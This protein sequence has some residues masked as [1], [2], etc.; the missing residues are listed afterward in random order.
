VPAELPVLSQRRSEFET[1]G[2]RL[3]VSS[4]VVIR[5][6]SDKFLTAQFLQSNGFDAPATH[7]S[8]DSATDAIAEDRLFFPLMVK[9][10]WGSASIGLHKVDSLE[11]LEMAFNSTHRIVSTGALANLGGENSNRVSEQVPVDNV[12]IQEWV[13]GDEYGLDV[14]NDFKGE[15]HSVYAKQKL[16][17]RAGDTD[18][19]RLVDCRELE[20]LGQRLGE[21]LGHIGN[22]DVDVLTSSSEGGYRVL[23]LNPRFG[24]GYPFSHE[25]GARYPQALMA[26]ATGEVF[27]KSEQTKDFSKI[28]SKYDR[29]IEVGI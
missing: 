14:L 10:R 13:D 23:E 11:D 27:N 1:V 6:C 12:I 29:L 24:G 18:R 16:G 26:W 7:V 22:L 28:I 4:D 8:F 25:L 19:A 9:P 5:I 2:T 15:F 3:F 17:M 21:S 20:S